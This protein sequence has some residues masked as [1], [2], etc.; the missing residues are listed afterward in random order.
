[1]SQYVGLPYSKNSKTSKAAA[2]SMVPHA[3]NQRQLVWEFVQ[4]RGAYGATCEEAEIGLKMRHQSCSTRMQ[5]LRQLGR[6]KHVGLTRKTVANRQA[7]IHVAVDPAD[8]T[9][10]RPGW[11][12]PTQAQRQSELAKWKARAIKA[13]GMYREAQEE[14]ERLKGLEE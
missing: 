9:D 3:P 13:R 6:L 10:K 7:E 12:T 14:I 8:W 11:P 2:K 4:K 1:M 5:E